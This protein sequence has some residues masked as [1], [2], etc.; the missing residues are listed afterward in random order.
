MLAHFLFIKILGY[1]SQKWEHLTESTMSVLLY[2]Y[3][4]YVNEFFLPT[5]LSK[6]AVLFLIMFSSVNHIYNDD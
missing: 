4:E 3:T 6:L 1:F 5:L 2:I